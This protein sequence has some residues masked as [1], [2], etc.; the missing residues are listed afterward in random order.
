MR[1][2][3]MAAAKIA[4]ERGTR[5]EMRRPV[6]TTRSRV[7]RLSVRD[8][9]PPQL[10]EH[11]IGDTRFETSAVRR[12]QIAGESDA[13]GTLL[14]VLRP[15]RRQLA[16]QQIGESSRGAPAETGCFAFQKR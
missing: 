6:D 12:S 2:L 10:E 11:T 14:H 13:G 7:E 3:R 9:K 1:D 16:S 5:S 4:G 15:E 8:V